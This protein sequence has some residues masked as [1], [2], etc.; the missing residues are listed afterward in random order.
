MPQ[1]S[2]LSDPQLLASLPDAILVIEEGCLAWAN[3]AAWRLLG[4]PTPMLPGELCLADLF[5]DACL[6]RLG[7]F[8]ENLDRDFPFSLKT[9]IW[10]LDGSNLEVEIRASLVDRAADGIE[11]RHGIFLLSV[12]DGVTTGWDQSD[13]RHSKRAERAAGRINQ[14][15]IHSDDEGGFLEESC[16]ILVEDAGFPLVWIGVRDLIAER[17]GRLAALTE[18]GE[19]DPARLGVTWSPATSVEETDLSTRVQRDLS[20]ARDGWLLE[21]H[22]RGCTACA[23]L[24]LTDARGDVF[25]R[26]VLCTRGADPFPAEELAQLETLAG[27]LAFALRTLRLRSSHAETQAAMSALR[28]EFQQILEWQVASQTAA[29]IAHEIGQPLNA[30][31]TFGEAALRLLEEI[32]PRPVKLARAVEGM[33]AQAERAGHVVRELMDFLRHKEATL[34]DVNLHELVRGAV[35]MAQASLSVVGRISVE[36]EPGLRPVRV[37]RLQVEKVLLNLIANAMDAMTEA[38][39]RGREAGMVLRM[40]ESDGKARITVADQGPGLEPAIA[41]H[42]FEPFFTTKARGIGMGL[43]ISR[44]LVEAQ[45]GK[46]WHEYLPGHGAIFHFTLPFS[47]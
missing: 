21:A 6:T 5:Q 22:H 12:R 14:A 42:V 4:A 9:R 40:D 17:G 15:L 16:R 24:P 30:V 26:L 34:E 2:P 31:T 33:A 28:N 25:G 27:E 23:C 20:Q 47:P 19:H 41:S 11:D 29:A 32:E 18:C 38:G 35:S 46:L 43:A 45:G 36:E 10:R 37:N 1:D 39:L 3:P 44:A 13:E 8:L 7:V